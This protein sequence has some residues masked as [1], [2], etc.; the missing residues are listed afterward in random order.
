MEGILKKKRKGRKG[1]RKG[2]NERAKERGNK[3]IKTW[4][5]DEPRKG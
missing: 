2:I 1:G 5:E 4:M 3:E